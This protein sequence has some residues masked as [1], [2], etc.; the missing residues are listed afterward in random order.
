MAQLKAI[1]PRVYIDTNPYVNR[2][3]VF[4]SNVFYGTG[5]IVSKAFII[6]DSDSETFYYN[7]YVAKKDIQPGGLEPDQNSD[8]VL[9]V[10]SDPAIRTFYSDSEV[11]KFIGRST[12]QYTEAFV[13]IDSDVKRLSDD[14]QNVLGFDSEINKLKHDVSEVKNKNIIDSL[15][16]SEAQDGKVVSWDSD[17]QRFKFVRNVTSV[18][19]VFPDAS[20]NV[21]YKFV[22][23]KTGN[24]DDRL[25]SEEKGTIFVVVGDSDSDFNG[26]SYSFTD[27]G[28]TRLIGFTE[29]ENQVR[30][31]NLSGDTMTG[32]L[33]LS[34]DPIQDSEAATKRY[35]DKFSDSDKQDK[36]IF[37]DNDSDLIAYQHQ[38]DRIYF[39]RETKNLWTYDGASLQKFI[40]PREKSYDSVVLEAFVS[41]QS[42]SYFDVTVKTYRFSD[43]IGGQFYLREQTELSNTP[44]SITSNFQGTFDAASILQ[45]AKLLNSENQFFVFRVYR[46][47]DLA[48]VWKLTF[49]SHYGE[50]SEIVIDGQINKV[51][52]SDSNRNFNFGEY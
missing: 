7:F 34:R 23:V 42:A 12:D 37:I 21:S 50:T 36:I 33:I 22:G 2:L 46:I 49:V 8:W 11:Y 40:I 10:A 5:S 28:W 24:R 48:D 4:K 6:N 39:V 52:F 45:N 30:Y 18:N 26:T 17:S 29:K 31:V 9:W 35:V 13:Q 19:G 38:K 15:L 1:A 51:T 27:V 47:L 43:Q 20:G 14:I 3:P 32:P 16:D 44:F 25:D 41:D